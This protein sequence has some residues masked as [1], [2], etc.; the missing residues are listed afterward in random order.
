MDTG[1]RCQVSG[2]SAAAASLIEK[3]TLALCYKSMFSYKYKKANK[4]IL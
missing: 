4:E 2:V 3:E 1:V